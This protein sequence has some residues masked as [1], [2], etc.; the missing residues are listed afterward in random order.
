MQQEQAKSGGSKRS[1]PRGRG[2]KPLLF[3]NI[4]I[5]LNVRFTQKGERTV[6]WKLCVLLK[7]QGNI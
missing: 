4:R 2:G 1:G 7:S 3:R 5:I 6:G